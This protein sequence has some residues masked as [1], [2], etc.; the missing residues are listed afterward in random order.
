MSLKEGHVCG[1]QLGG[2]TV[3]D[4]GELQ[5]EPKHRTRI[6]WYPGMC[7]ENPY[8]VTR[9]TSITNAAITA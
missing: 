3:K 7:I 5:S 1:I 2:M 4:L 9:L 6:E 8:A